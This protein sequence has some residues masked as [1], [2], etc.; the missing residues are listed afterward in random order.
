M[1][2]NFYLWVLQMQVQDAELFELEAAVLALK[3]ES[4]KEP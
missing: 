1:T 2:S 3:A 4:V